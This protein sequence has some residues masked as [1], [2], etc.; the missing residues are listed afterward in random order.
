MWRWLASARAVAGLFLKRSSRHA[1]LAQRV[2]P[3]R[4][5]PREGGRARAGAQ[6]PRL[7]YDARVRPEAL[8]GR[9]PAPPQTRGGLARPS[10]VAVRS[11]TV[12]DGPR[13][14]CPSSGQAPPAPKTEAAAQGHPRPPPDARHAA[15][16]W[17]EDPPPGHTTR[18]S[19]EVRRVAT[20][21]DLYQPD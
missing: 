11:V 10:A 15:S 5:F 2:T 4:G 18:Y 14:D 19:A 20:Y 12:P 3:P 9:P 1:L 13:Q 7:V 21:R 8:G 6:R 16:G 17:D